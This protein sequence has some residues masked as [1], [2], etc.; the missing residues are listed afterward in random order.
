MYFF[1]E[2]VW[3]RR[4]LVDGTVLQDQLVE[5]LEVWKGPELIAVIDPQGRQTGG[6]AAETEQLW[7]ATGGEGLERWK[8]EIAVD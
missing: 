6:H 1:E 5:D 7:A 2:R 4:H 8:G 3:Q